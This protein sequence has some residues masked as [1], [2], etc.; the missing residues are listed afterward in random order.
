MRYAILY[1]QW[2]GWIWV[3][4]VFRPN[5][6]VF[7]KPQR[8]VSV[9]VCLFLVWVF[10]CHFFLLN[11]L[12]VTEQTHVLRKLISQEVIILGKNTSTKNQQETM[13]SKN[14]HLASASG[15]LQVTNSQLICIRGT[16]TFV[17]IPEKQN[18]ERIMS[19]LTS[20]IKH[21]KNS[22]QQRKAI[23]WRRNQ[24][25]YQKQETVKILQQEC[26]L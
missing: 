10:Y 20:T 8:V 14:S 18:T 1:W 19:P 4:L 17:F 5:G 2:V 26:R 11:I 21:C 9:K 16:I 12:F 23:N 15:R 3:Q 25:P 6:A 22:W 24:K 13:W 7:F